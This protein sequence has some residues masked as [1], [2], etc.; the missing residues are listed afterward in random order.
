MTKADEFL[1][2]V[3]TTT[4]LAEYLKMHVKTVSRLARIGQLPGAK[5]CGE[6][7]DRK[8]VV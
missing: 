2:E 4:E 5:I 1:D 3:M 8:S 6:W 7:R